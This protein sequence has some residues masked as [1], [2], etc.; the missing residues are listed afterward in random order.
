MKV[1]I[2][3]GCSCII[4]KY[5]RKKKD[6]V[7]KERAFRHKSKIALRKGDHTIYLN[8]VGYTD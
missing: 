1:R 2:H 3:K 7:K 5:G 6:R 4:C 8:S